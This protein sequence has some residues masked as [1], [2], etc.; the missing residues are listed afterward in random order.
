MSHPPALD[1]MFVVTV[2]RSGPVVVG[3]DGSASCDKPVRAVAMLATRRVLVVHVFEPGAGFEFSPPSVPPAPST[4]RPPSV[5]TRCWRKRP[6]KIAEQGAKRARELG[7]HSE[8]LAATDMATVAETLDALVRKYG[9]PAVVSGPRPRGPAGSAPRQYHSGTN[10]DGALPGGRGGHPPD[11][12]EM[13]AMNHACVNF[14]AIDP[15]WTRGSGPVH[16]FR[17]RHWKSQ[18][19]SC[20]VAR[21][22]CGPVNVLGAPAG[23]DDAG[24]HLLDNACFLASGVAA[25]RARITFQAEP[26][27]VIGC[28]SRVC[29][30]S[31]TSKC[32]TAFSSV[33]NK[34]HQ[35]H[36][37]Q[38]ARRHG[39]RDPAD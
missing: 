28:H 13:K 38:P 29:W 2:A 20:D 14:I 12:D 39:L 24:H 37:G 21:Q 31:C 27:A 6:R 3:Y 36:S 19:G 9:S 22:A 11:L 26:T 8:A 30:L 10:K 1:T 17:P 32:W 5:Q 4:C 25:Y 15:E 7:L 35:A 18:E 34:H 16:Q 23:L 33:A